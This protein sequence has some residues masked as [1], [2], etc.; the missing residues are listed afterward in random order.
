[1]KNRINKLLK[2]G[3]LCFAMALIQTSCEKNDNSIDNELQQEKKISRI[4]FS[5][6][7]IIVTHNR[8][9][10]DLEKHFDISKSS[11]K[12]LKNRIDAND[13]ITVLT[14]EILVIQKNDISYYTFKIVAPSEN[15]EF[16][17]LVVHV[18]NQQQIIK[19][20]LY[21][22]IPNSDWL[23]DINQ[24]YTGQIKVLDNDI[25]SF[26]DLFSAR[27][28]GRCLTGAS[29]HWECNLG[30]NH[31]PGEGVSCTS[32]EYVID[33]Q[34]GPCPDEPVD[35]IIA[36]PPSPGT[37]GG[38]GGST[39][40]PNSTPTIPTTPCKQ[41]DGTATQAIGITD[42]DGSCYDEDDFQIINE[43]TGKALCVY[44]KLKSSSTG[45]K[46]SI[47]K[48][49][50]EFPVAHLKFD[51]GDIGVSRGR[52][53]AP[54]SNP[55]SPNSPDFVITVRLNN[56]DT[57]SGVAKRPNLL[58]AK[59]IAHEVIHAEMYRKLLSVLDNG[60]SFDGVTRQDVLDALS[61][62][63]FPGMYDYFRRHKNW[64]HQQMATHYRE[65]LARILQEYDTGDAVP[66]NQQPSQFYMDLSWEGLRYPSIHTWSS[67]PQTEKDR[68]DDVISDYVS[69]N[70]NQTCIE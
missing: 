30:N 31:A 41:I 61:N 47:K 44:N 53:I 29:G 70:L 17:N 33:L 50:P 14:D 55:T 45:F 54:N 34:Y 59:T 20:E 19:S 39:P 21:E 27:G 67:L 8:Q 16:Y 25:I 18:N 40:D 66:N 63:D 65:S 2:I 4:S 6:F 9:Y 68:I 11:N 64:Q 56:N 22:Y 15:N 37:G 60:G 43:L 7:N 48:F 1:M 35:Y 23:Q 42:G 28:S 57:N 46:N 49:E 69:D 3:I 26:D 38:S 10:Q 51:M 52:T 62:G 24:P 36:E 32:W 13:D 58:I 12:N 5:D